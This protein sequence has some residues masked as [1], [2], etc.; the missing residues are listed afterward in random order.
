MIFLEG[1][2]LWGLVCGGA[3]LIFIWG[4]L[5]EFFFHQFLSSRKRKSMRGMGA[6]GSSFS[7]FSICNGLSPAVFYYLPLAVK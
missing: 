4:A 3:F 5:S 2:E 7:V 1:V 6:K